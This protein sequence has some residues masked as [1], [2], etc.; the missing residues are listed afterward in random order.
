MA[1]QHLSRDLVRPS[2]GLNELAQAMKIFSVQ[3]Q[4]AF[5]CVASFALSGLLLVQCFQRS[6]NEHIGWHA[7]MMKTVHSCAAQL[8]E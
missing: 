5:M 7:G 6:N 4:A 3:L 2:S 8:F 1:A